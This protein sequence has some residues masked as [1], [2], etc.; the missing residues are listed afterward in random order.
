MAEVILNQPQFQDVNKARK[1]LEMLRWPNGPICPHCGSAAQHCK[2][3]GK[4][5]RAGL[6][7]CK[8]CRQQ[9]TVTVGTLFAGSKIPLSKWLQA[10]YL[11]SANKRG[12]SSR[13]LERILGVTYKT[14]WFMTHRISEAMNSGNGSSLDNDS[15]PV[16]VGKICCG[17]IGKLVPGARGYAQGSVV[18]RNG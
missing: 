2:L 6:Y 12:I 16:E 1:Y 7:K 18:G 17:N 11:M 4:A 3:E 15:A 10:C 8:D 9:F 14:A 13:Q 5:H